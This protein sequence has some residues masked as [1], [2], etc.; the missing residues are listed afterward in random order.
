VDGDMLVDLGVS[1]IGEL[2]G[3]DGWA[4]RARAAVAASTVTYRAA[5]ADYAPVVPHCGCR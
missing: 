4:G 3:H 2:L 1:D 5:G